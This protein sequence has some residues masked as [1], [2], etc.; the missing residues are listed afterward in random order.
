MKSAKM[1]M[2]RITILL[3]VVFLHVDLQTFQNLLHQGNHLICG[4]C[5]FLNRFVESYQHIAANND[6]ET[7]RADELRNDGVVHHYT[8]AKRIATAAIA[9]TQASI[10]TFFCP[11]SDVVKLAF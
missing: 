10:G 2:R 8:T 9:A 3:I 5:I 4:I 1:E 6:G 11:A 7:Q